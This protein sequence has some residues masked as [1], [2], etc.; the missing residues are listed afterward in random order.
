MMIYTGGA[1]ANFFDAIIRPIPKAEASPDPKKYKP[2][3]QLNVDCRI[4]TF[5]LKN[6]LTLP[7]SKLIP[8][9]QTAFLPGRHSAPKIWIQDAVAHLLAQ[10]NKWALV[11]L[12][13]F[14]KAYD[15]IDRG[16]LLQI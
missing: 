15:T 13:D 7:M 2:I 8:E 3:T 11:G 6:R 1:P 14:P 5:V 10:E 12:C 4:F 9:T 16:F